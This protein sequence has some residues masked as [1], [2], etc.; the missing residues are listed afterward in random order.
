MFDEGKYHSICC[1]KVN[2]LRNKLNRGRTY[3]L[4]SISPILTT[5]IT[6]GMFVRPVPKS[7][8]STN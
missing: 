1:V 8:E 6:P 2:L 3:V 5:R 7:G 4:A